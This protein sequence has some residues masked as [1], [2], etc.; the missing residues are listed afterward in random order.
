MEQSRIH[1]VSKNWKDIQVS[2]QEMR[3]YLAILIISAS[4]HYGAKLITGQQGRIFEIKQ[5]VAPCDE[6]DL[7]TS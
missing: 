1:G 3:V 7:M 2:Q 4:I 5:Y 6:I